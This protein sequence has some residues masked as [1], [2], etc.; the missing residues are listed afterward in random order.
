MKIKTKLALLICLS[1]VFVMFAA[2][3][4]FNSH[5]VS[6]ACYLRDDIA[7]DI[8]IGTFELNLLSNEYFHYHLKRTLDQWRAKY[9]SL[10]AVLDR[11]QP[12]FHEDEIHLTEIQNYLSSIKIVF[13]KLGEQKLTGNNDPSVDIQTGLYYARISSLF[14]S[15]VALTQ[16]LESRAH[17]EIMTVHRR[18]GVIIS[19]IILSFFALIALIAFVMVIN[20]LKP[21]AQLSLAIRNVQEGRFNFIIH[22]TSADEL[23]V[24]SSAFNQMT[25]RLENI[26]VS[27]DDLE[28]EVIERKMTEERLRES[29]ARF[30]LAVKGSNDGIWDWNSTTEEFFLSE[31]WKQIVGYADHEIKNDLNEWM[32]RIHPDDYPMVMAGN[33]TFFS[34]GE[35]HFTNEHRL[36]HKNGSYRWVLMRGICIRDDQGAPCRMSG[37]ITDITENKNLEEQLRQSKKM[38]AVGTLSGGIAHEFNNILSIILGNTELAGED[39]VPDSPV[40]GML[41]DIKEASLRGREV[42]RHLL[43]FSRP[44]NQAQCHVDLYTLTRDTV[45]S[46]KATLPSAIVLTEKLAPDCPGISGDPS[47]VKKVIVHLFKNAV[48]AFMNTEGEISVSLKRVTFDQNELFFNVNLPPGDYASLEIEDNGQGIPSQYLDRVFDPFFSTREVGKG[49]G[50]GLAV[51]HGVMKGH[52]GGIRINSRIGQGAK[53]QCCFPAAPEPKAE[54]LSHEKSPLETRGE[55]IVYIDDEESI[56]K[57]AAN[58]LTRLGYHVE[59]FTNPIHAI[60]RVEENSRDIDLVMTD[61]TM[62]EMTGDQVAVHIRRINPQIKIIICTGYSEKKEQ[63]KPENHEVES[64]LVKPFSS[65]EMKT[66]ITDVLRREGPR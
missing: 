13:D 1:G 12:L 62:P 53:V 5:R 7:S 25:R 22:V 8:L 35:S 21:I 23:G 14:Q 6:K 47:M 10:R 48:Q 59:T 38:E 61:L 9:I 29:E 33:D 32:S 36:R 37:A 40:H 49:S 2:Y 64:V 51:V 3:T 50:L 46:L 30:A 4:V 57:L 56:V 42:V 31:R 34:N 18:S 26:T 45:N 44:E 24:M 19:L 11:A 52:N 58:R 28:K 54:A 66:A 60:K 16:K 17:E 15:L 43:H 27:R 55:R 41:N 65:Q 63:W 20:V 39:I